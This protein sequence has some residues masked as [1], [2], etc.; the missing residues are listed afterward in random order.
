MNNTATTPSTQAFV[1]G[2]VYEHILGG[3]YRLFSRYRVTRRTERSVW[4]QELRRDGTEC[5]EAPRRR[6]I[7]EWSGAEHCFPDGRYRGAP[8]LSANKRKGHYS[9]HPQ[10]DLGV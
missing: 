9:G 2:E 10:R 3:D 5:E 6:A 8:V 4:V 1:V 7:T